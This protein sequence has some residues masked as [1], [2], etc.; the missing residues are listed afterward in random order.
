[1]SQKSVEIFANVHRHNVKFASG[2]KKMYSGCDITVQSAIACI[3]GD[4]KKRSIRIIRLGNKFV[5]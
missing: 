5:C 1:M 4:I 3:P 2:F